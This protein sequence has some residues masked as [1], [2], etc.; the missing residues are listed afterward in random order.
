MVSLTVAQYTEKMRQ[1][2]REETGMSFND[3]Q[4]WTSHASRRGGAADILHGQGVPGRRG[5]KDMLEDGD[6]SSA[7]AAGPYTPRDEIEEVA[8][9]E[10]LIELD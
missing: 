2:L 8:M 4:L 9:G 3:S 7:R 10:L 1:A 6:W 5:L